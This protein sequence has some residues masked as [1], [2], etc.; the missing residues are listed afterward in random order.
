MKETK[1]LERYQRQVLLKEFGEAGQQKLLRA[2]V[3]VIGAGGLG[4]P[5]LQYLVAAGVGTIGIVDDDTVSLT[6]LHRQPLYTVKDIG[7]SK[8]ELA[9]SGLR[10][11]NPDI[12]IIQYNQRP[13]I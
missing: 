3:V 10:Q 8:A 2:K 7:L 5:V 4:C 1:S 11:L 6:N 12:N 13:G 9:A